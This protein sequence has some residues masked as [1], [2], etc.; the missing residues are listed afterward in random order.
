MNLTVVR[1]KDGL[2]KSYNIS[3]SFSF[4]DCGEKII[5]FTNVIE[6]TKGL[7]WVVGVAVG[8]MLPHPRTMNEKRVCAC[9]W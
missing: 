6:L 9:K 5:I 8:C 3:H 1:S 4:R 2:W 7:T